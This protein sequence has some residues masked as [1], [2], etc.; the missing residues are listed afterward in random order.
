MSFIS[1]LSI[2]PSLVDLISS[3][4]GISAGYGFDMQIMLQIA[5]Y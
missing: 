5:F 3:W 1:N 4:I 2:T